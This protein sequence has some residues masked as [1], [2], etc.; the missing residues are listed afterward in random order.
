[1]LH[2]YVTHDPAYYIASVDSVPRTLLDNV[3]SMNG[4]AHAHGTD[5]DNESDIDV[6]VAATATTPF[7]ST[8]S[9]FSRNTFA[10]LVFHVK[11]RDFHQ[12]FSQQDTWREAARVLV[13]LLTSEA[14]PES[15]SYTHLTLPTKA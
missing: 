5:N 1:M 7:T 2:D 6:D 12:L 11:Y 3:A 4:D 15:V 14:T 9:I 8:S 13:G 10:P